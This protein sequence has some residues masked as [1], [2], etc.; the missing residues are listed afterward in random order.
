MLYMTLAPNHRVRLSGSEMKIKNLKSN[1][2]LIETFTGN[3]RREFGDKLKKITLFG[4]RARGDYTEDSDYDFILVFDMVT[5]DLKEKLHEIEGNML[6][7]HGMVITA[8]PY[9]NEDV[10]KRRFLPFL[11]NVE[12]ERGSVLK[13]EIK[14]TDIRAVVEKGKRALEDSKI[15][16]GNKRFESASSRAYYSVFHL[17]QAALMIHG[18]SFSKHSAVISHFSKIFLKTGIFPKEFSKIIERLRKTREIGGL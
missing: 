12:K 6:L 16:F 9:T 15:L 18:L 2:K 4:S 14:K 1:D 5:K 17:L 7:E 8:I 13:G 11:L 10:E 3:L